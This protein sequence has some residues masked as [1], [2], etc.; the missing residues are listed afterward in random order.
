MS[1]SESMEL[2]SVPFLPVDP[3]YSATRNQGRQKLARFTA[4]ELRQLTADLLLEIHCRQSP[5]LAATTA[6]VPAQRADTAS[7][8]LSRISD[9]EPL[10]DSVASDEDYAVL[11]TVVDGQVNLCGLEQFIRLELFTGT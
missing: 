6:T 2:A 3:A 8:H 7:R 5:L 10:Y 9:D 11:S 4:S 1:S